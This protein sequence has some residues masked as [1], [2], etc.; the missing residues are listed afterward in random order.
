MSGDVGGG[1]W[2]IR[3][4]HRVVMAKPRGSDKAL[5]SAGGQPMW[6]SPGGWRPRSFSR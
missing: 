4:D 3:E 5:R 6:S 2:R 1:L